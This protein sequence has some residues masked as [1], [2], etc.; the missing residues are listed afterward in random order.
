MTQEHQALFMEDRQCSE[1]CQHVTKLWACAW[2]AF[3]SFLSQD[4]EN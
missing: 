1:C 3:L 4:L 2:Y